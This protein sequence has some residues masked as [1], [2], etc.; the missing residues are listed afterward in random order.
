MS[1]DIELKEDSPEK[2]AAVAGKPTKYFLF[3]LEFM[4]LIEYINGLDLQKITEVGGQTDQS[5]ILRNDLIDKFIAVAKG[6]KDLAMFADRLSHT[7]NGEYSTQISFQDTLA[8]AE[9]SVRNLS[10]TMALLSDVTA[11]LEGIAWKQPV[12]LLFDTALSQ[13][14]AIPQLESL[15]NQ[16]LTLVNDSRIVLMAQANPIHNGIY[17]VNSTLVS[18]SYRLYRT[19]DA[20][21]TSE[22]NNAVVGVTGGTHAG[23]T[24]RQSTLNP[25]IGT[26]NIVFQDFGSAVANATNV[27]AGI[28]KLYNAV[29]TEIDGGITPNAVKLITDLKANLTQVGNLLREEFTFSGSQTFTLANNYGQVYSVEVQGQGALSTS[30]YTLVAPNKITIND[31]LDTSDYVVVIYSNAIAGIQ[32]YYSQAE[33][34]ALLALR[35]LPSQITNSIKVWKSGIDGA[36]VANTLTITPAYTQLIPANTF[37]VG[38]VVE[39]L[40]RSTSGVAK[41]TASNNYI[42]VNTT[43]DLSGTPTQIGIYTSGATSR[44]IQIERVLAIKGVTTK[45]INPAGTATSD[46]TISAA[47]T[48]LTIDWTVNQ[49]FVFAIGHT[50]ADQTLTGDFYRIIK[51]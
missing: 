32:P 24:Y 38:D 45:V 17:R 1:F 15:T 23:K 8:P 16:G 13:S 12:E 37:A 36:T 20:N 40:F 44:T 48:A 42:Y 10:G 29:G 30:Q 51:N 27:L 35:A 4:A 2:L 18:G 50:V 33:V 34:D 14:G 21:T 7:S 19:N 28:A 11:V 31:T 3:A 49:Y 22:L 47:M 25:V 5:L 46:T 39:L 43:N 6:S 26:S 9:V 41:T